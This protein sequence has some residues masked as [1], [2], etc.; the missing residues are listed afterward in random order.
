MTDEHEPQ[1][2]LS[3]VL[4]IARDVT[5]TA[6]TITA[7]ADVLRVR[8]LVGLDARRNSAERGDD[9]PPAA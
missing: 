1:R 4:R 5:D 8:D 6:A 3:D 9:L 7:I 2:S